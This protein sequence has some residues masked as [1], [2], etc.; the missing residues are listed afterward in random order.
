M[1][2]GENRVCLHGHIPYGIVKWDPARSVVVS[3]TLRGGILKG[4]MKKCGNMAIAPS[5]PK[6]SP[7]NPLT[8]IK[9]I[10]Q[11]HIIEERNVRIS[12]ELEKEGCLRVSLKS[13]LFEILHPVTPGWQGG[14][15]GYSGSSH[16]MG[17]MWRSGDRWEYTCVH[18]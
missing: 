14:T 6:I 3:S 1:P 7:G 17:M 5:L 18:R 12:P 10:L 8:V 2:E 13:H 16:G 11:L 15:E 4:M 9:V